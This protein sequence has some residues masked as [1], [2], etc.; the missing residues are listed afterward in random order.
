MIIGMISRIVWGESSM[1]DRSKRRG[2]ARSEWG[3]IDLCCDC[4]APYTLP[5]ES[6]S[7]MQLA[8]VRPHRLTYFPISFS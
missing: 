5:P 1:F 2:E 8:K 3:E 7:L 4:V 6:G